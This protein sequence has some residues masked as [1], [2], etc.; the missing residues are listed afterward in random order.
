MHS[1]PSSYPLQSLVEGASSGHPSS[2]PSGSDGLAED[3]DGVTPTG[4]T[5]GNLVGAVDDGAVV[6]VW[7]LRE[8]VTGEGVART[9][10]LVTVAGPS[11][12]GVGGSGAG[13]GG[14]GSGAAVAG[15]AGVGQSSRCV[16][17]YHVP[18]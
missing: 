1:I 4:A 16:T 18:P 13:V 14:V 9:G 15:G 5:V 10:A 12:A 7:G 11:G 17:A 2:P 6:A 8:G 3:G